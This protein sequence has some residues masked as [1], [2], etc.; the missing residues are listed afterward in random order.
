MTPTQLLIEARLGQP[1]DR[2]VSQ[3]RS[4]D[5]SWDEIAAE[6]RERGGVPTLNGESVR[7]WYA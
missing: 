7:R 4:K 2:F 1:L 3:L 6:L 5:W